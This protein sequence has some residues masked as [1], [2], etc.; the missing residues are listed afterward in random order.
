MHPHHRHAE[1]QLA[2]SALPGDTWRT[3]LQTFRTKIFLALSDDF[4]ARTASELCGREDQ[5]KVSYNLS[6]SG[7]D[8]RVSLLT[9]KALSHKANITASKSY[10][11]Q[12]DFRFDMKTFT[13]LSNAQSVIVAYDGLNPDAADVLLPQALLQRPE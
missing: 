8:A 6:E 7:H 4:S 1:H 11:T 5:L 3:L 2:Q 12:T 13:E 9:G 10:N